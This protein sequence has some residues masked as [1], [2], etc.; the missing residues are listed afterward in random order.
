MGRVIKIRPECAP[1]C[2]SIKTL[3]YYFNNKLIVSMA[4]RET[5]F[6][7]EFWWGYKGTLTEMLNIA[8][9]FCHFIY[10]VVGQ[11]IYK[12]KSYL[13]SGVKLF[14]QFYEKNRSNRKNA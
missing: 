5:S 9:S 6:N 4:N 12:V 1:K 7:F 10:L 8:T 2:I 13:P 14:K 3:N 11:P